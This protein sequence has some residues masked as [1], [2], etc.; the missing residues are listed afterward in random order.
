[1]S[2]VLVFGI[3]TI[4]DVTGFRRLHGLDPALSDAEVA[5]LA[6][7]MRR[8]QTGKDFLP[9][10]LQRVV[11]ISCVLRSE[12]GLRVRSLA[13]PEQSEG[14][15]VQGFF[16]G[17]EE[18]T[19]RL[20]SWNGSGFDLPVL[21]CRG[22]VHGVRAP[23]HAMLG[24]GDR[25]ACQAPHTDLANLLA[26][27]QPPAQVPL[28]ELAKLIGFPGLRVRDDAEVWETWQAGKFAVV[29]E[30]CETEAMNAYLVYLRLRLMRG[31]MTRAEYDTEIACVRLELKA[32][33]L[34]H[35]EEFLGAWAD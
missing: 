23:H 18:S 22:L 12:R 5:E 7:Q 4:P 6:F 8:A 33:D 11:A 21:H 1:M 28:G 29:R 17:L 10:H 20:V 24:D 2:A 19:P 14:E 15:I 31:E 27:G 34:P 25:V 35:W 3:E 26:M 16:D 32:L 9:L 13:E 30:G